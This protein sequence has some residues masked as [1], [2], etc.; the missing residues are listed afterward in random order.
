MRCVKR[1]LARVRSSGF[2]LSE[3]RMN[4]A[5][6][7]DRLKPGLRTQKKRFG[8]YPNLHGVG[9][10]YVVGMKRSTSNQI[11]GRGRQVKG[12]L[13]E[14]AGGAA[15]NRRLQGEGMVDQAAGKMQKKA[16]DIE[17]DLDEELEEEP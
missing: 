2:S 4:F 5:E 15:K 6:H 17:K 11:K 3:P 14:R 12:D 8:E 7:P 13:K 16:G 9:R 10:W 1:E